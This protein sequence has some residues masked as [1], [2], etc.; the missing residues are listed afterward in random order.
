MLLE[1]KL[2]AELGVAQATAVSAGADAESRGSTDDDEALDDDMKE[3]L[4]EERQELLK[5][6]EELSTRPSMAA[7]ARAAGTGAEV[8]RLQA[9]LE[10]LCAVVISSVISIEVEVV[11]EV[12][13]ESG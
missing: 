6:I 3:Y 2:H 11:V 5:R 9:V 7:E 13:S 12:G 4:R 8:E 1:N 10:E